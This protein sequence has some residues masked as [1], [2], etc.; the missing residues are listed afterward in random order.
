M[1]VML[2]ITSSTEIIPHPLIER[3]REL[4]LRRDNGTPCLPN[5]EGGLTRKMKGSSLGQAPSH[6][7]RSTVLRLSSG[8][9]LSVIS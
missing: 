9:K 1:E 8:H 2:L 7:S 6:T 4:G 3:L 5:C